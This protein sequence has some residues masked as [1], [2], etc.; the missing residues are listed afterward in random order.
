MNKLIIYSSEILVF[1]VLLK[2]IFQYWNNRIFK[3]QNLSSSNKSYALF[4]SSQIIAL[5]VAV[6]MS[7]E[8]GSI[9]FLDHLAIFSTDAL[10]YWMYFSLKVVGIVVIYT[11][12]VLIGFFFYKLV[13][14]SEEELKDE[15][16]TDNWAPVLPVLFIQLFSALILSYFVLRPI[17]FDIAVGFKKVGG[18]YY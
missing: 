16:L 10:D 6:Y 12:S 1:I 5:G 15:I 7:V 8:S 2:F 11:L 14:P 13:I 18:M 3:G 4:S 9:H 17:L